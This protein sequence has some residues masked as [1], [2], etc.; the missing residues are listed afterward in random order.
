MIETFFMRSKCSCHEER[1]KAQVIALF[2]SIRDDR[3]LDSGK[4][5]EERPLTI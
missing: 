2:L 3:R 1:E 4:I 5:N